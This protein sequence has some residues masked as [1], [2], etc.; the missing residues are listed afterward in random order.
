MDDFS[1]LLVIALVIAACYLSVL[2]RHKY[3]EM[4]LEIRSSK[5][6][7]PYF[8]VTTVNL[9]S[10]IHSPHAPELLHSRVV[11]RAAV[12]ARLSRATAAGQLQLPRVRTEPA[13]HSFSFRAAR[14]WNSELSK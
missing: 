10:L 14:T 6:K 4:S 2:M 3:E 7:W 11:P 1:L 5:G 13:R 9:I 12:S 8:F